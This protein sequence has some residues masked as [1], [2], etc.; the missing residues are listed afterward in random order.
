M[1][2]TTENKD[3]NTSLAPNYLVS[4]ASSVITEALKHK[5]QGKIMAK[6]IAVTRYPKTY[7]VSAERGEIISQLSDS[8][9]STPMNLF[10]S[11]LDQDPSSDQRPLIRSLLNNVRGRG[12]VNL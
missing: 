5:R 10:I 3:L 12:G 11:Q 6:L 2:I 9:D 4:A 7:N 8:L 1:A